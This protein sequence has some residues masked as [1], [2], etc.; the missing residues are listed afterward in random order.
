[1][2][3]PTAPP[4]ISPETLEV[5]EIDPRLPAEAPTTSSAVVGHLLYHATIPMLRKRSRVACRGADI[6]PRHANA[7]LWQGQRTDPGRN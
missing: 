7:V 4:P 1:M 2:R 6:R 5:A 3:S